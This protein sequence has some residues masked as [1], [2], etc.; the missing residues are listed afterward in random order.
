MLFTG[1]ALRFAMGP[2]IDPQAWYVSHSTTLQYDVDTFNDRLVVS[3]SSRFKP[4]YVA[5]PPKRLA[6]AIGFA[7]SFTSCKLNIVVAETS[8]D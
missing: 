1:M 8:L 7:F 5:G 3:I 2:L 6:Q 4:K